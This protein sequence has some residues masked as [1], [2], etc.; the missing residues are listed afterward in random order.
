VEEEVHEAVAGCGGGEE[1]ESGGGRGH[2]G[3]KT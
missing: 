2:A 1:R 3:D